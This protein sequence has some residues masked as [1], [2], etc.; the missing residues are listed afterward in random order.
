M[1]RTWIRGMVILGAALAGCG[2]DSTPAATPYLLVDGMGVQ[3]DHWLLRE[4][5]LE[6]FSSGGT[7]R[8]PEP[9]Q[10][11]DAEVGRAFPEQTRGSWEPW[12]PAA[13]DF[14]SP[15]PLRV[16]LTLEDV[17]PASTGVAPGSRLLLDEPIEVPASERTVLVFAV[18]GSAAG[19]T[20]PLLR[21]MVVHTKKSADGITSVATVDVQNRELSASTLLPGETDV[22]ALPA[23]STIP[24]SHLALPHPKEPY[25]LAAFAWQQPPPRIPSGGNGRWDRDPTRRFDGHLGQGRV[26]AGSWPHVLWR[27]AVRVDSTSVATK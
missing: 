13:I 10:G 2:D 25:A 6:T 7:P 1:R 3:P 16:A 23:A 5:V 9:I 21:W 11:L 12:R 14:L 20:A 4:P 17:R 24:D 18:R 26:E 19:K 8:A 27:L 22:I 15:V